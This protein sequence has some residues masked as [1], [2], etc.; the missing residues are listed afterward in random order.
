M[1]NP[2]QYK[3]YFE[4]EEEERRKETN[5]TR[6]RPGVI[7]DPVSGKEVEV[8]HDEEYVP[9]KEKKDIDG[10]FRPAGR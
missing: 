5:K 6:T 9:G 7:I 10:S 3:I 1:E 2:E 8:K 4:N